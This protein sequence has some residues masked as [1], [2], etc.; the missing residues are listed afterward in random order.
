MRI[1]I[2]A[3]GTMVLIPATI[4]IGQI[5]VWYNTLDNDGTSTVDGGVVRNPPSTY[6]PGAYGN[7]FAGNG[8]L[9]GNTN[10]GPWIAWNNAAIAS[11][12]DSVWN[13]SLGTT[14]DLYFRGDHWSTH[15]GDSGLW[16]VF[17]RGGGYD[18]HM[19]VQVQNGKLRFPWRDSYTNAV[20]VHLLSGVTLADN[21]TYRLTVRQLG[22]VFEVYLDGG[23]YSNSS[24]V[25]VG[26]QAGTVSFPAP[27][28]GTGTSGREMAVASKTRFSTGTLQTGEWVDNIRVFNGY[29]TPA[30]LDLGGFPVAVIQADKTSG[31]PPLAVNFD[32]SASYDTDGGTVTKYEWD[33]DNDGIVD[34]SSGALVSH[35]YSSAGDYVC[36]LTVTDNENKTASVTLSI[37][38]TRP[39]LARVTDI[40]PSG[41]PLSGS[42]I[43][44]S[45][46]ADGFTVTDFV[47]PT[48]TDIF[49]GTGEENDGLCD[50]GAESALLG[51]ELGRMMA[52]SAA[53]GRFYFPVAIN[54]DGT[55]RPDIFVLEHAGTPDTFGIDL[56]TNNPGEATVVAATVPVQNTDYGPTGTLMT[57][58]SG[59]IGGV[60]LDLDAITPTVSN[61]TGVQLPIGTGLDPCLVAAVPPAGFTIAPIAVMRAQPTS[62][63]APLPV[64][65]DATCGSYDP[66]GAA[67][68]AWDYT[69]DGA[70][71]ARGPSAGHIYN[72]AGTF[73]AKLIVTD[74]DNL[75]DNDTVPI[76]VS[77]AN[78]MRRIIELTSD[79]GI[80][81]SVQT[82]YPG[83]TPTFL[84]TNL[85]GPPETNDGGSPPN[86]LFIEFEGFNDNEADMVGLN[87][88]TTVISPGAGGFLRAFFPAD[89]VINPDGTDA[90]EVFVIEMTTSTD[91][92]Q[93]QLLT[94]GPGEPPQVAAAVQVYAADYQDAGG[95]RGGVGLDLDILG[96]SGIRGAQIPG[97]DGL[98]GVSGIDPAVI[99]GIPTRCNTP[100]ADADGDADVDQADF[101]AFQACFTGGNPAPGAFDVGRCRCFDQDTDRDVDE[102]DYSA[103]EDHATGPGIPWS[104]AD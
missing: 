89:V 42:Q 64:A 87:L 10:N 20:T 22:T 27:N 82:E 51:L 47:G 50:L 4:S 69:N 7:A 101:S 23:A 100:F 84:T 6:V 17:D 34:N 19:I 54:G 3:L 78:P 65:F 25:Y 95:N 48:I 63:G 41:G 24:P 102:L 81:T 93:F 53:G 14:I 71:D 37:H 12:F 103:F 75:T 2:V 68:F 1:A 70:V 32:G 74:S 62:G 56:L 59:G 91:N 94:S 77:G 85:V 9:A 55:A 8:P 13:N 98:G 83:G 86:Y 76:Q 33:F 57:S 28:T 73:I 31:R 104:P 26:T 79:A 72:A 18:G 96:V 5:P 21:V 44:T 15:T 88:S 58:F 45:I 52:G 38:V 49:G 35:V 39:E 92:F 66:D 29:Y 11:I 99:A 30:E 97:S 61:I 40:L 16:G 36:K 60:G 46:T 67:T 80:L 43:L 90:P